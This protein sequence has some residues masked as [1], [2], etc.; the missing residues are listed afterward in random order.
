MFKMSNFNMILRMDF[1]ARNEVEIDYQ[2]KK[3]VFSTRN[4]D[5]F[6]FDE[7]HVKSLLVSAMKTRKM[8]SK[9]CI[10]FLTY[11]IDKVKLG[12]V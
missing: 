3:V 1:L 10:G 7:G 6:E 8:L 5:Q 12:Q 11:I 9:E 2:C 4:R